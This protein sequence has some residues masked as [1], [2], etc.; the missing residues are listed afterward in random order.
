M[1]FSELIP[2]FSLK[3]LPDSE[4]ELS[5]EVPYSCIEKHR[6][7]ALAHIASELELP[8]FRKG[9]VPKDLV[10]KK[11]GELAVLEESAEFF[12]RDFYPELVLGK[13]IDAL[14]RPDI[15]ITKLAP[16]NPIALTI[17][18][19]V[20]PELVVP[21]SWKKIAEGIEREKQAEVTDKEIEET[22]ES[23]RR[24]RAKKDAAGTEVLPDLTDDFAHSIGSFKDL[25]DLKEKI[26]EG[27]DEE[28]ARAAKDKRRGAIIEAL[29]AKTEVNLPKVFVENELEKIVAQ[30]KDDVARLGISFDDY[31]KRVNKSEKEVREEFRSQAQKRAKLQLFLNELARQEK[32]EADA[33]AVDEEMKHATTH[34]PDAKPDLLRVHIETV[35]RNEKV[36]QALEA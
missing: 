19:A 9:N 6:E 28:K 31:L 7:D 2:S 8:G 34:F 29:L 23:L 27:I 17:R 10:L 5:G 25:A 4:V 20:Y 11:V 16:G 32:I 35:L 3:I 24:G 13:K 14:G 21:R 22:L 15:R 26:K 1:P 36:L 33:S 12:V 30:L 18:T